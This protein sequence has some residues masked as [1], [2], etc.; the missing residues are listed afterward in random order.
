MGPV[1]PQLD[2]KLLGVEADHDGAHRPAEAPAGRLHLIGEGTLQPLGHP[3]HHLGDVAA[4]AEERSQGV[5]LPVVGH[6]R[7]ILRT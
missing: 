3:R 4:P 5:E 1:A 7:I 2:P 6:A